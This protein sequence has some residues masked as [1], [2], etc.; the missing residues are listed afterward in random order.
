LKKRLN[1][2]IASLPRKTRKAL[3]PESFSGFF[4]KAMLR[5]RGRKMM[6]QQHYEV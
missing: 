4:D 6:K 3:L 2:A 1:A 5:S